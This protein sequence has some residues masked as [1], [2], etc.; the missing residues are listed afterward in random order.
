[1]EDV[2]ALRFVRWLSLGL[3][4]Y[5]VWK[6]GSPILAV[7]FV[8]ACIVAFLI[9][10]LVV[11]LSLRSSAERELQASRTGSGVESTGGCL[12]HCKGL[13]DVVSP[14]LVVTL[15]TGDWI[16]PLRLVTLLD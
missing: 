3:L 8:A 15:F 2:N 1:M 7:S 12:M 6:V 9:T 10:S 16:N 11:Y 13:I 5:V 4:A 14:W